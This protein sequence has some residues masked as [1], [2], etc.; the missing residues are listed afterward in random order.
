MRSRNKSRFPADRKT[1]FNAL[2]AGLV[3]GFGSVALR[4]QDTELDVNIN[5]ATLTSD[6]EELGATTE[7]GAFE[8]I[9]S[10]EKDLVYDI[11]R[12]A[13]LDPDKL[14]PATK[15]AIDKL[16]TTNLEA[17][18]AFSH[19]LDLLDQGRFQEAI[20]GFQ[21]AVEID[22]G[23]AIA[24][25]YRDTT[26]LIQEQAGDIAEASIKEVRQTPAAVTAPS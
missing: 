8:S 3:L 15:A 17:F 11:I 23:F 24:V 14:S 9:F 10:L 16:Q 19:S 25:Q 18:L 2:V 6:A 4:G 22:P 26:P 20:A 21:R 12:Q 1:W 5:A 7:S 13:G